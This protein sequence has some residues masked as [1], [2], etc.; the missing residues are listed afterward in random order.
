MRTKT[1][2]FIARHVRKAHGD[3]GSHEWYHEGLVLETDIDL[4]LHC[5]DGIRRSR[6][7]CTGNTYKR[8]EIEERLHSAVE[9]ASCQLR[10]KSGLRVDV[11]SPRIAERDLLVSDLYGVSLEVHVT[12]TDS[13][14]HETPYEHAAK[15][16]RVIES[17][18]QRGIPHLDITLQYGSIA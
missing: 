14:V 16:E 3:C 12:A 5:S 2:W 4:C 8:G 6:P 1:P 13:V 10:D 7:D 18:M 11:G 9:L 17:A 15:L